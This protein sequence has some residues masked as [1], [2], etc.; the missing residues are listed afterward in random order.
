MSFSREIARHYILA[1]RDAFPSTVLTKHEP[2]AENRL[3]SN[4]NPAQRAL[5]VAS[6]PRYRAAPIP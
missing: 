3:P 4:E 1:L 2:L 5:P 6:S